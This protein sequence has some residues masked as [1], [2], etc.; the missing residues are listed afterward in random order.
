MDFSLFYFLKDGETFSK[1]TQKPHKI[2]NFL[3]FK[4]KRFRRNFFQYEEQQHH[5]KRFRNWNHISKTTVLG[6]RFG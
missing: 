4:N 5:L 3:T 6:I 1:Y 2:L